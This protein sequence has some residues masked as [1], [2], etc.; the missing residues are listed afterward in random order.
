MIVADEM[1]NGPNVGVTEGYRRHHGVFTVHD[2]DV[3]I[4][5]LIRVQ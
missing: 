5:H 2:T 1:R 3:V 4:Q